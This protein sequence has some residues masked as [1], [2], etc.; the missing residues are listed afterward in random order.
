MESK[1]NFDSIGS[2]GN[3]THFMERNTKCPLG[4]WMCLLERWRVRLTL[5]WEKALPFME[6]ETNPQRR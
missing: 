4:K 1:T 3:E 5:H 2:E 6:S